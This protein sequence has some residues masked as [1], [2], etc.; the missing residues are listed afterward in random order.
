M[1]IESMYTTETAILERIIEPEKAILPPDVARYLLARDFPP[2]IVS[3][4][5][6]LRPKRSPAVS[7][8]PSKPTWSVTAT[9]PSS[10]T[11]YARGHGRRW[12]VRTFPAGTKS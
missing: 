1:E 3:A 10:L 11:G 12:R 9:S 2:E 6:N 4:W 8:P 7:P 5:R